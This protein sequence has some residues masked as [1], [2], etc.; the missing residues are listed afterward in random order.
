[1]IAIVVGCL[2]LAALVCLISVRR[3]NAKWEQAKRDNALTSAATVVQRMRVACG[4]LEASH[5]EGAGDQ[6]DAARETLADYE[7]RL[8][9]AYADL[10]IPMPQPPLAPLMVC[11]ECACRG[12]HLALGVRTGRWRRQC[13]ECGHEFLDDLTRE[14]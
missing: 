2:A 7:N 3:E 14:A 11:P 1:M 10:G 9:R 8:A 5:H 6:L 13:V 12:A 4:R